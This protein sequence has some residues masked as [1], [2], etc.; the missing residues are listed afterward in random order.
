MKLRSYRT[1]N[2]FGVLACLLLL[3]TGFYLEYALGLLP[4]SLCILQRGVFILMAFIMSVAALHNPRQVGVQIYGLITLLL[5]IS[6]ALL[7]GRQVWLHL[8]THVPA[9]VCLPGFSYMVAHLPLSQALRLMLAGSDDCGVVTWRF[10][11]WSIPEWTLL[12]FILFGILSLF[13]II[14]VFYTRPKWPAK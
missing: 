2:L 6:G 10:L 4:C 5:S 9:E 8:Q 7:A 12:C 3:A 11:G 13:Q 1:A 14:R